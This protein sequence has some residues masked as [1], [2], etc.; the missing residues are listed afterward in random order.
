MSKSSPAAAA[1]AAATAVA[2]PL[3]LILP[4]SVV[5]SLFRLPRELVTCSRDFSAA[6]SAATPEEE[7]PKEADGKYD[8]FVESGATPAVASSSSSS[9]SCGKGALRDDERRRPP[10]LAGTGVDTAAP[11]AMPE[12]AVVT[13]Y[14]SPTLKLPTPKFPKLTSD[15]LLLPG[16]LE[17]PLS[18]FAASAC[19]SF[20]SS[21][22]DHCCCA[23]AR[24]LGVARRDRP[25]V[26]GG[27]GTACFDR[28]R[29]EVAGGGDDGGGG[30]AEA[31]SGRVDGG[32]AVVLSLLLL[33][34]L[35][36]VLLLLLKSLLLLLV[37]LLLLLL[38]RLLL[39]PRLL[40]LLSLLSPSMLLSVLFCA[41]D[42][43]LAAGRGLSSVGVE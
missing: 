2:E 11:A 34:F 42:V 30:A 29:E 4:L 32:A 7:E 14:A 8:I 35:L 21:S 39:L 43:F 22:W 27:G 40:L 6:I 37:L 28:G 24:R 12:T 10:R 26:T 16:L 18:L 1:A 17:A 5:A 9:S 36:L 25:G 41:E 33:L 20:W 19:S 38:V 3:P 13:S 31:S 23:R 15:A